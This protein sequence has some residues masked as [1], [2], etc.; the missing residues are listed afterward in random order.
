M[1]Q[2]P[3]F[4]GQDQLSQLKMPD[5]SKPQ[6]TFTPVRTGHDAYPTSKRQCSPKM[7]GQEIF[8]AG[9]RN[10]QLS[11]QHGQNNYLNEQSPGALYL[12][13]DRGNK[14]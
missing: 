4:Y 2:S 7:P 11:K 10:Q 9:N 12:V 3:E 5:L 6:I 13:N 14:I 1:A 8:A